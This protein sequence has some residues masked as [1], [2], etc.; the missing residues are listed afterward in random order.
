[1]AAAIEAAL[2]AAATAAVPGTVAVQLREKN[3]EGRELYEQGRAMRELC[4]RYRAPL[5]VNDRIDLAMAIGADGVHLP[6]DSFEVRDAR[7][8]LGESGLI[9][10]STHTIEEVSRAARVG[11]DFVV[12]GPVYPPLS[13]PLAG[14]AGGVQC[15]RAACHA[16]SGLPV[17]A[18]GGITPERIL[19]FAGEGALEVRAHPS[20]VAVIGA[21]LGADNPVLATRHLIEAVSKLGSSRGRNSVAK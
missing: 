8:L 18:L 7:R 19:E 17:Y 9:G 10:V 2:Y 15:L 14:V 6:S 11:A 13:K 12:F 21:V 4:S 20:G 3:L 16:A 5:L 1:L